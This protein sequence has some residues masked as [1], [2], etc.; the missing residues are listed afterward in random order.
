MLFQ[1]VLF[2]RKIYVYP[3]QIVYGKRN[4]MKMAYMKRFLH[5]YL[6][7]IDICNDKENIFV[8]LV[9]S[10]LKLVKWL[11]LGEHFFPVILKIFH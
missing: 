3:Q 9:K 1:L 6:D 2:T 7:Y 4:A 8:S 10:A 5:T 11:P